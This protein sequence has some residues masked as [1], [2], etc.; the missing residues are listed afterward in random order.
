MDLP[1]GEQRQ[2]FSYLLLQLHGFGTSHTTGTTL[3][4]VN[5]RPHHFGEK[6]ERDVV[7][8]PEAVLS[9]LS[10]LLPLIWDGKKL[11]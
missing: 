7:H 10:V 2:V 11:G 3:Y 5:E 1:E 6:M 4:Q 9:L 8:S